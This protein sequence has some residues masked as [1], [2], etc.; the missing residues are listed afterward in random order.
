MLAVGTHS[1]MVVGNARGITACEKIEKIARGSW[2]GNPH[3]A[4]RFG[5]RTPKATRT[6]GHECGNA[7]TSKG[8]GRW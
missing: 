6:R 2:G 7:A 1:S 4:G 3:A 5:N 8:S